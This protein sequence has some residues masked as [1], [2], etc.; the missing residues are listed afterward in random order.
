MTQSY[1]LTH[2]VLGAALVVR[3]RG[4]FDRAAGEAVESLLGGHS[5]PR[6]LNLAVVEYLSSTGIA[7][8]AKLT[9]SLELR[10]AAPA[11]CVRQT[12]SLAGIERILSIFDDEAQAMAVDG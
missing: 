11:D 2:E 3:A 4:K 8:L 1:E 6:V 5:G 9:S 10:I 7:Y 12:V